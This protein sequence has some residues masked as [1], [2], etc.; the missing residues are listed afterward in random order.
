MLATKPAQSPASLSP[1]ISRLSSDRTSPDLL[2][3]P[4]PE[5]GSE[6]QDGGDVSY[7]SC[8]SSDSEFTTETETETESDNDESHPFPAGGGERDW[9][10]GRGEAGESRGLAALG[11]ALSSL[12]LD[13]NSNSS[14][15]SSLTP[16]RGGHSV[17]H[18]DEQQQQQQGRVCPVAGTRQLSDVFSGRR[19]LPLPPLEGAQHRA[20][21]E[22]GV[23]LCSLCGMIRVVGEVKCPKTLL[24]SVLC[25]VAVM[26]A[27]L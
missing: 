4:R 8:N 21:P 14:N 9:G 15:S 19:P 2:P 16:I 24:I 11:S 1:S 23:V 20:P 6:L 27:V 22:V 17:F 10:S 3:H 25:D 18:S 12:A 5:R 26:C 7:Y 13:S